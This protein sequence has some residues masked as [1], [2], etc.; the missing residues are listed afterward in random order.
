MQIDRKL[1]LESEL[2]ADFEIDRT[3]RGLLIA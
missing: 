3:A 2:A 1:T